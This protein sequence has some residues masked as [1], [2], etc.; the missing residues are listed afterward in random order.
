MK[1]YFEILS[2]CPLFYG[3]DESD[4]DSIL[5]C[6]GGKITFISK[7][8]PV[9]L[10]GD[11]ANVVGIVL[12]G[13]VQGVQDDYYGNRSVLSILQ[14]G[15]SFGEAFSC[16]DLA[17]MPISVIALKDSEILLLN[18]KRVL[19]T[20]SHVC[21]FHNL[22]INNLMKE[23]ANKNLILSQKIRYMSQKTTEAKL[24]AY[25]SDHA[26]MQGRAEFMI[27]CDRQT[28]ADYLGVERSA[29]STVISNL[30]KRGQIDTKG[31][32]FSLKIKKSLSG[33]QKQKS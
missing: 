6:L 26:K 16:A 13:S 2:Q 33:A 23:L 25:L 12:S 8:D 29:M 4:M 18:C 32:W 9:F 17:F 11:P 10:E 7:G 19:T 5:R 24:M 30:K 21:H 22:L 3:M 28:L 20:C 1:K 27:P 14:P 15:D 31:S